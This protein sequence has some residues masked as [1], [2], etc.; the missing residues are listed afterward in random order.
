MNGNYIAEAEKHKKTDNRGGNKNGRQKPKIHAGIQASDS[1][2]I[3]FRQNLQ[4]NKGIAKTQCSVGE[5]KPYIKKSHCDIH[6][7]LKQ[8]LKAVELLSGEHKITTLCRVLNVNRSTYYKYINHKESKRERENKYI[9]FCILE[10]YAKS[11]I[12][13]Y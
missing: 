2:S 8:R 4:P 5:R 1:R 10:F 11:N 7:A 3:S 13:F 12:F 9:R 6:A